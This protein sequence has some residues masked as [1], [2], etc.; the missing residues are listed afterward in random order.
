MTSASPETGEWRFPNR[1]TPLGSP[2]YYAVRFSPPEE[3]ERNALLLGWYE[4]IQGIADR[5]MDP[6]VARLK[7]DWWREEIARLGAQRARHPLAVELQ[8]NTAAGGALA[9]ML[10]IVDSTEQAMLSPGPADDAAFAQACRDS[11]GQLFVLLAAAGTETDHDADQC[12]RAGGYCAAVERVRRLAEDPHRVPAD[13]NPGTLATLPC[14]QRVQRLDTLL[15]RPEI[16]PGDRQRTLPDLAR[17]LTALATAMHRKI[18]RR[19]YPVADTLIDRAPIA[20][21]WTAWRCR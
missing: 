15:D 11:L 10:A 1:A 13:L 5:P 19:G 20:H 8:R 7:L 9:P 6:G 21:L 3:R 14:G 2:S 16:D 18:R 17:R 4:L 12:V